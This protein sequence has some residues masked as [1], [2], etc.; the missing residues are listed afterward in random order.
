MK[1]R[2]WCIIGAVLLAA[3]FAFIG[4]RLA[5]PDAPAFVTV[6]VG[7]TVYA[8][9]PL[10][11]FQTLTVDQGDGRVNVIVIDGDGVRMA[12]STCRNQ[13]CVLQGTVTPDSG[14]TLPLN[15][16]II[17]LPNGVTVAFTD[18]EE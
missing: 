8:R 7:D 12:S 14:E 17:C 11:D 5:R 16:R 1:K 6:Y 18:A 13:L 10:D 4:I 9:V 15:G 3:L 2:D